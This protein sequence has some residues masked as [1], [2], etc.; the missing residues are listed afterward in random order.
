MEKSLEALDTIKNYI[1]GCYPK[2]DA[3]LKALDA[4]AYIAERLEQLANEE[5]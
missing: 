5:E 3:N 2:G 1:K 4:L